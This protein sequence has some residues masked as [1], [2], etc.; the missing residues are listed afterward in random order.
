MSQSPET[1]DKKEATLKYTEEKINGKLKLMVFNYNNN[2]YKEHN[3]ESVEECLNIIKPGN[4]TWINVD[5]LIDQT[6][7][8]RLGGYFKL[9]PLLMEDILQKEQRR[10]R[11][12]ACP[13]IG[14]KWF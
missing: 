6:V 2:T 9:H 11:A 13:V 4:I 7:I 12:L 5:S 8:Q 10:A 1:T 3:F 14:V